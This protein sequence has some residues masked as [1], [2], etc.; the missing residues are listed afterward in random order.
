MHLYRSTRLE[1]VFWAVYGAHRVRTFGSHSPRPYRTLRLDETFSRAELKSFRGIPDGCRCALFFLGVRVSLVG[2]SLP[3]F[4]GQTRAT[5]ME[6]SKHSFGMNVLMESWSSVLNPNR[7]FVFLFC[8]ADLVDFC[9]MYADA[10]HRFVR[11]VAILVQLHTWSRRMRLLYRYWGEELQRKI[12]ARLP[13]GIASC[14]QVSSELIIAYGMPFVSLW[15][16]LPRVFCV[17]VSNR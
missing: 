1:T 10:C 9:C 6:V 16:G 13:P 17:I 11:R 4:Q 5:M 7:R 8:F 15:A 2:E 3:S 12:G 14:D